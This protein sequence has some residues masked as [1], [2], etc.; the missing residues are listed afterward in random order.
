M[1]F[2]RIGIAMA[3]A[4]AF[5][6]PALA[7]TGADRL[8]EAQK[9]EMYC[10]YDSVGRTG[11]YYDIGDAYLM[12]IDE[13]NA[14][15]GMEDMLKKH[16]DACTKQ[17]AWSQ[18]VANAAAVVGVLG[19]AADV[20]EEYMRDGGITEANLD[21]VYKTLNDLSDEDIG[22]LIDATWIGDGDMQARVLAQLAARG[23]PKT[24]DPELQE[25]TLTLMEV[26]ILGAIVSSK[27][28]DRVLQ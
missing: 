6:A 17:Y 27:W 8:S 23:F 2:R 12:N 5:S 24:D 3:V 15:D 21:A 11:D 1:T 18:D 4:T 26:N 19:A 14:L 16:I 13:E 20:L 28:V 22:A 7:Q 9:N 10:I 25:E